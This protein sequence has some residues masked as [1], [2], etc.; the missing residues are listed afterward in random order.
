MSTTTHR[1]DDYTSLVLGF[2]RGDSDT[3][4]QFPIS[5]KA[6]SGKDLRLFSSTQYAEAREQAAAIA[7]LLHLD[8][9]D[10]STDHAVTL[11][12]A[13]AN[14]SLQDRLRLDHRRGAPVARPVTLRSEITAGDG[15]V[16]ISI[17]HKRVHPALF[18]FFLIPAAVPIWFFAPF[19]QFFAQTR[20]PDGV[21]WVFLAFLIVAF[22]IL[23]V[24]SGL[25][26]FLKSR[27]GRTIVTVSPAG[28]RV[29]ERRVW[30]TRLR[31]SLAAADV[32]DIDYSTSDSLLA[33]ARQQAVKSYQSQGEA[34][35]SPAVEGTLVALSRIVNRGTVTVKTRKGLTSF[36]EGL[37]DDEIRYLH[38]V[39]RHAIL[40]GGLP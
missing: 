37:G 28:I 5:L 33:S 15:H 36:G 23:P 18:L 9:E 25:N 21:A 30:K 29:D 11:S 3:A 39:V 22:G 8:I 13:E 32:M 34:R 31:E 27:R 17:P 2:Q 7:A 26:A 40:Y 35:V 4:D 19:S 16:V 14:L 38:S 6:R 10:Q 24:W 12:A 20:T 1:A